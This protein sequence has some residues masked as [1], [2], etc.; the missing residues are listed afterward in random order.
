MFRKATLVAGALSLV[1]MVPQA[2]AAKGDMSIS[3]AGG[4]GI[5]MGDFSKKVAEGGA[6]ASMGFTAGPSFDYMITDAVA[7]GVDGSFTSN[8]LNTD[9]RDLVRTGP[10]ADPDFNVK[11]TILGGGAHIKYHF[12]MGEGSS[13]KPY[14]LGGAGVSNLKAKVE[15]NDPSLAGEGS[16]TKFSAQGALGLAFG[17]GGSVGYGLEAAYH[18]ISADPTSVTWVGLTAFLTFGMQQASK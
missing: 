17:S 8:N 4:L 3:L 2:H 11:Y 18:Y 6:G 13:I 15:S 5:P 10:P 14:L 16:D 7:I 1:L 9:E 12:P